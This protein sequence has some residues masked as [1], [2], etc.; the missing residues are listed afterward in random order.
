MAARVRVSVPEQNKIQL[1]AVY[2]QVFSIGCSRLI[3]HR[4][5]SRILIGL[6]FP[7]LARFC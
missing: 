2:D 3:C 1:P 6:S 7:L 4:R 5:N